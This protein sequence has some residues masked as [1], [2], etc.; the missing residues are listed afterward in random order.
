[1]RTPILSAAMVAALA[2][3]GCASKGDA[4][5][6]ATGSDKLVFGASLSLTGSLA[7]E[8]NLTK[9]GYEVCREVI[10]AKG[11]VAVG[12][13]KLKLEIQ[14]QD[15]T[16]KPDT[17]GQLIDQYNGN[18][19]KLILGPYGSATTEAAAAVIERNN[20]VMAEGAGADDKIFAK[21]YKRT[22]AV[23]SPAKM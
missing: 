12:A 21:G 4:G 15:D 19:I 7:R 14:F 23:L 5:A 13:K 20:Q 8:G 22:F 18:G 17:A 6:G 1:M 3:A 16:S 2:M 11:G 10:N 9:E